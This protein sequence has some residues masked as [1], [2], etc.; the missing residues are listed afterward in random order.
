MGMRVYQLAKKLKISNKDLINILRSKGFEVSSPSSTVANIYAEELMGIYGI[1]ASDGDGNFAVSNAD[2]EERQEER[3]ELGN[4]ALL[5]RETQGEIVSNVAIEN[6]S[7]DANQSDQQ[8][9]AGGEKVTVATISF[10]NAVHGVNEMANRATPQ[11]F[12]WPSPDGGS[13]ET[14]KSPDRI[15]QKTEKPTDRTMQSAD[16][17]GKNLPQQN[18]QQKLHNRSEDNRPRREAPGG[19]I[20]AESGRSMP[21]LAPAPQSRPPNGSQP[22]TFSTG[23]RSPNAAQAVRSAGGGGLPSLLKTQQNT[24]AAARPK[25][26]SMEKLQ[27]AMQAQS[28]RWENRQ[29][30]GNGPGSQQRGMNFNRTGGES[31]NQ[32]YSHGSDTRKDAN[33]SGTFAA[34]SDAYGRQKRKF[35]ERPFSAQPAFELPKNLLPSNASVAGT[36]LSGGGQNGKV[37]SLKLPE[38]VREFANDVGLKPFQIIAE[39]MR[40]GIF[41]SMNYIIDEALAKKLADRFGFQ[42]EVQKNAPVPATPILKR[43]KVIKKEGVLEPRPP[44]VCVLGHVD[45]G[46]TTLLDRIR[47]TNVVAGEAGGIT[48]HIGAYEVICD[49]KAITFIDTPGHAAFSKMRERGANVTDIAIL[50]VAA[51]DG[52]M[53][54]TDEALKFAQ[55]AGVPVIVAIN[56]IDAKGANVDRV[57]QQM[58]Q[59]GI[60]C[61]EWGGDTLCQEISALGGDG[62]G[63]LLEL[64]L[65]QAE[66]MELRADRGVSTGGVILESQLEV[67]R[68]CTASALIQEGTLKVGDFVVCGSQYAKVRSLVSDRGENIKTAPPSK[69][70]K[71]IGWNGIVEVGMEFFQVANEKEARQRTEAHCSQDANG[72]SEEEI[73]ATDGKRK[74]QNRN[75]VGLEALYAA[76]NAKQKRTLRI[77]VKGDVQG[78]VEALQ[79][80]LE[81]LPQNKIALEIMRAEVGNITKSDVEF[82]QPVGGT[83][84]AFNVRMENG[85]QALLKQHGIHVVQHSIIYE[86]ITCV[87]DAMADL[88]DPE[89]HEEKLGAAQIREVFHLSKRV[90]AGCMVTEGKIVRDSDAIARLCCDGKVRAE[91]K[92]SSLRRKKDDINEVRAGFECGITIANFEDYHINDVIECYKIQKIRPSL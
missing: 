2:G 87:R 13:S 29:G 28:R 60:T 24:P 65:T 78:S 27:S 5:L 69:P 54:Q 79:A 22:A 64:V 47:K 66:M 38:S 86:L 89:I 84:V 92:I 91:G 31:A 20:V 25:M 8:G 74:F 51:D 34:N 32:K 75:D 37:F 12:G 58:Q 44:V 90:V 19:R 42:F 48:Q 26:I 76:I 49:G 39:L 53:P 56:K 63:K 85:V 71:I 46:K 33:R 88:L 21:L 6:Q 1:S 70:V 36:Q 11:K 50:V 15:P 52:F 77:V 83:I 67:G 40:I 59:R 23:L 14:Q 80:S 10:E 82:A 62:I 30:Q 41:A 18:P 4:G 16:G 57:K 81:A 35:T 72:E 3:S 43:P 55:R 61:E 73:Q 9:R 68:G 45:H 7:D 17:N